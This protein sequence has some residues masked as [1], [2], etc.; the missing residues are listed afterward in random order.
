M[1]GHFQVPIIAYKFTP[2]KVKRDV[3][4][5]EEDDNIIRNHT[6]ILDSIIMSLNKYKTNE[7]EILLNLSSLRPPQGP[8]F[9]D[10]KGFP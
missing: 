9:E 2:S 7:V 6:I 3:P 8:N 10:V 5:I 1:L 4:N